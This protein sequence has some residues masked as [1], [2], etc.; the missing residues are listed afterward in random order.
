MTVKYKRLLTLH[1][2]VNTFPLNH[3]RAT[4]RFTRVRVNTR[5]EV[6]RCKMPI[7]AYV[8][9]RVHVKTSL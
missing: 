3:V 2:F 9:K 1:L 5:V 6:A 8:I 4:K 7:A